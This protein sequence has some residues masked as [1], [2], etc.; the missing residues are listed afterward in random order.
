MSYSSS[1]IPSG[2][3]RL[4]AEKV[5]SGRHWSWRLYNVLAPGLRVLVAEDVSEKALQRLL[6]KL[7]PRVSWMSAS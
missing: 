2:C 4:Q 7:A 3:S 5:Y 1:P 6:R